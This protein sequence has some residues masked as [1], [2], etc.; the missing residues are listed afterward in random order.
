ISDDVNFV[1]SEP[2]KKQKKNDK[3]Y[4]V[5]SFKKIIAIGV[6]FF[7]VFGFS[8]GAGI[9]IMNHK[10]FNERNDQSINNEIP[11]NIEKTNIVK[12]IVLSQE[13]INTVEIV[14]KVSSSVVAITSKVKYRDWYNNIRTNE[15]SGS[16][17]V[18][19]KDDGKIYIITNN[20]VVDGANELLV[21]IVTDDFQKAEVVGKDAISDI[22]VIAIDN[23]EKYDGTIP[24]EFADSDALKAGQKVIALGNPLGYN[25][26]V[27][28][29]VISALD[30]EL[31]GANPFKLIQTD[32][33]INPGNSGGALLNS[34]GE[35]I[36]IN[37]IKIS[38]TS[39]EGIGFAIPVNSIVPILDEILE[40]GFVSR[41]YLGIYGKEVS[42]NMS[43]L[44]EIPM[45]IFVS[46]IV[47]G[48]G[49]DS[50]DLKPRDIIIAI[51][52]IKTFTMDDLTNALANYKVGDIVTMKVIRNGERK[53]IIKVKLTQRTQN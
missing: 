9:G 31:Q 21:E 52:E 1:M 17:V 6:I 42:Q 8:I 13:E 5:K 45:G 2:E 7:M 15:S 26:T 23:S 16:G 50:S 25:N 19:K 10:Y 38:E 47:E 22:A 27:T 4:R 49:A 40:N 30:R 32:A 46:Q 3:K 36:G 18:F 33:A 20:H 43:E 12:N 48:S 41:P 44:Y 11:V 28:V 14:D 35:L 29:G 53:K 24:V 37:T 34:Q 51:D 39:V